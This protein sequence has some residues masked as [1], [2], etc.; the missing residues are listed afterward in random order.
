M[1]ER[2]P[3][4]VFISYRHEPDRPEHADRVLG[5][6]DR[7]RAN[8]IDAI[9]DQYETAPPDGWPTWCEREI[10]SADFVL[11]FCT[12]AYHRVLS[13][14]DPPQTGRG[15]LWE[16]R[17]IRPLIYNAGSKTAK[18]VPAL[19]ADGDVEHVPLPL[20]GATWHCIDTAEGYEDLYRQL[21]GQPN[22]P[23]PKVETLTEVPG[24]AR[25]RNERPSA[26]LHAVPEL[27]PHFVARTD[28]VASLAGKLLATEGNSVVVTSLATKVGIRRM[29]GIGKS[30]LA[31][32]AV[33]EDLLHEAFPGG[34]FW[35]PLGQTP[36][37]LI[38]QA[39]LY[40]LLTRERGS[41][42][43]APQGRVALQEALRER[44]CLV[45]LDAV[46]RLDDS[47]A[48]NVIDTNAQ[49]LLTTRDRAIVRAI[50]A[51]EHEVGRLNRSQSFQ[52]LAE[53]ARVANADL[54]EE[55][56]A[57]ARECGDL[58]LQLSLAGGMVS[59]QP[60]MWRPV[61][62]E[63]LRQ[64]DLEQIKG[65]FPD[66]PY[67]HVFAAIQASVEALG[68]D[69]R[70]IWIWRLSRGSPDP[71]DG[72][73]ALEWHRRRGFGE[74]CPDHPLSRSQPRSHLAGWQSNDVR[75]AAGFR[76]QAGERPFRPSP[77]ARRGLAQTVRIVGQ[78][79]C[80]VP[81]CRR[82]GGFSNSILR[83]I[84]RSRYI[85]QPLTTGLVNK[86]G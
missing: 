13:G 54:P 82:R 48:F 19:F 12:E 86:T 11:M 84:K 63:T 51:R 85:R 14:G 45:V 16:A 65:E 3:P 6:A 59:G 70:A 78:G 7:L 4:R 43:D 8:G 74:P 62:E 60:D 32:A 42:A 71:A 36:G 31:A 40:W 18:F 76:A 46:W 28:Q 33:R 50:G 35:V 10:G 69:K 75:P 29:G 41:F 1:A 53:T 61:L 57:I 79:G 77:S 44:A 23:K 80:G 30:V 83:Y 20:R 52:L 38:R 17:I 55:A 68:P 2:R 47:E 22:A 49:L 34:I 67:P 81:G 15:V 37:L 56:D 27:P 39:D 21:T 5:L 73:R 24:R 64:A 9:I 66:Y 72:N 58:P 25:L 26:A